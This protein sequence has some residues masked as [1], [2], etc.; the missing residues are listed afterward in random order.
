MALKL[1]EEFRKTQQVRL[2]ILEGELFLYKRQSE[3]LLLCN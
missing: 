2:P 1:L 3:E